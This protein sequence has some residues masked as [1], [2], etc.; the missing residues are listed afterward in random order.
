MDEA[1]KA[2][3]LVKS[4]VVWENMAKM[5]VQT[6][7]LDIADVCLGNMGHAR[8]ARAVRDAVTKYTNANGE[9]LE[10]DVCAAVVAVQLNMV[11]EAEALY[12]GC[13]RYDL[14]NELY[15]ASGQWEKA[16]EI[17][18][19]K[20]RIHL[21]STHYRYAR[22]LEAM[23]DTAKAA[24]HFEQSDTHRVEVP[25]MLFDAQQITQLKEFIEQAKDKEL[26][27]WWAQYA[28]SNGRFKEAI[29]YYEKAS[30]TLSIV[31]VLCF[32]NKL[33]KA[34]DWVGRE[35]RSASRPAPFD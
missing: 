10:P 28:E 8:G 6:K 21:K 11:S 27:K 23:G 4:S 1:H 29:S 2:V 14:L 32:H 17:A 9:L 20:D 16:L 25:R 13:G 35:L 30:D 5:C 31:R 3:K 33:Q 26:Y 15:Q 24:T 12:E 7:R 18:Q 22:Q 34:N 19:T